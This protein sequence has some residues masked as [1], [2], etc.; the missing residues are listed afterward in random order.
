MKAYLYPS[1]DEAIEHGLRAAITCAESEAS[2]RVIL[3]VSALLGADEREIIQTSLRLM[4]GR[5]VPTNIELSENLTTLDASQWP[6]AASESV[7][8]VVGDAL[9]EVMKFLKLHD[10]KDVQVH[11][12][13]AAVRDRVT[14]GELT[15][16]HTIG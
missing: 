10:T 9:H 11:T 5:T 16:L 13:N 4:N 2:L 6:G 3:Y 15:S 1:R 7:R 14:F 12:S 8:I